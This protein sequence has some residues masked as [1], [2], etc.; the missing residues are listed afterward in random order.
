MKIAITNLGIISSN[1]TVDLTK[2]LTVLVGPNNTG[3]T[4]LS[5]IIH[6][7]TS[8]RYLSEDQVM[9]EDNMHDL[10][11]RKS[12]SIEVTRDQLNEV[13]AHRIERIGTQLST[14]FGISDDECSRLF[15]DFHISLLDPDNSWE[16][17]QKRFFRTEMNSDEFVV[18]VEKKES[19]THIHMKVINQYEDMK[20]NE[21]RLASLFPVLLNRMAFEPIEDSYFFTVERNSIPMFIKDISRNGLSWMNHGASFR[22]DQPIWNDN[23]AS[24]YPLAVRRGLAN[25]LN[26]DKISMHRGQLAPL[27]D[28]IEQYLLKGR[29]TVDKTGNIFFGKQNVP[30]KI[31]SS[32]VK[33][34]ASLILYIRYSAYPGMLIIIDEPEMNLHPD[35]QILLARVF[36][37]LIHA[38]IRLVIST[39]SDYIIR[40]LNNLIML[41]FTTDDFQAVA[42]DKGYEDS[43]YLNPEDVGAILLTPSSEGVVAENLPVKESG[44]NV[45]T[46]DQAIEGLN[47]DS[48]EIYYN[49]KYKVTNNGK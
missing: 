49:M 4:Y 37:M 19:D 13:A 41:H 44:F 24:T 38:G 5:Y 43:M 7:L 22:L 8:D 39:H 34:L 26:I 18:A 14:I 27:A 16:Q 48:V 25:T 1:V 6:A 17:F 28:Q 29:L 11:I 12:I 9:S 2:P 15:P 40:E 10:L 46:I 21:L 30:L 32:M 35:L 31:S 42:Q 36:G 20:Q 47:D 23:S 3:K 33:S 45:A